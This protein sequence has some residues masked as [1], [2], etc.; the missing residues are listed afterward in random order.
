MRLYVFVH[1]CVLVPQSYLTVY[2]LMD[3]SPP[4]SSVHGIL[5]ARILEWVAISF[6][7]GS[8]QPRDRTQFSCTAVRFFTIWATREALVYIHITNK[9]SCEKKNHRNF[10]YM[11]RLPFH[12][13]KIFT[14]SSHLM[15]ILI[16]CKSGYIA[17]QLKIMREQVSFYPAEISVQLSFCSWLHLSFQNNKSKHVHK[18]RAAH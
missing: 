10:F 6:S 8:S 18:E 11:G 2:N 3:C 14:H 17:Y 9:C 5:Q 16:L 4:G 1:V 7:R 12:L 13:E 15:Y